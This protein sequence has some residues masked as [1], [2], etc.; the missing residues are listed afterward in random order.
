MLKASETKLAIQ[1]LNVYFSLF[2]L[3]VK[4]GEIENKILSQL[5]AGTHRAFPYAKGMSK[6]EIL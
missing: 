5:L 6:T 4:K 1:L 3:L 2:K